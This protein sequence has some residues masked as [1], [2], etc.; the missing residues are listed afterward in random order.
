M[1]KII[2]LFFWSLLLLNFSRI[3]AKAQIKITSKRQFIHESTDSLEKSR[4][5]LGV[6]RHTG[7]ASW[8]Y[9]QNGLFAASTKFKKGSVVRVINQANDKYVDVVINDY[10]PSVKKHP[11]RIID[12]DKV[13]FK[14]IAHLKTGIISIIV[15][16]LKTL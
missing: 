16:P 13:A 12:L 6:K 7:V 10:G 2:L 14:K 9:H 4:D 11:D 1:K 3:E 15:C 8:Y 5:S